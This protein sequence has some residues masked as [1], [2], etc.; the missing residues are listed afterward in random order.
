MTPPKIYSDHFYTYER[1]WRGHEVCDE[2]VPVEPTFN[3]F[4]RFDYAANIKS[5]DSLIPT[6]LET[7]SSFIKKKYSQLIKPSSVVDS[8]GHT[9]TTQPRTKSL[10]FFR[11]Y[12]PHDVA[13]KHQEFAS[14]LEMLSIQTG[15]VSFEIIATGQKILLVFSCA[16]THVDTFISLTSS[17][18]PSLIV[19]R[20]YDD[21]LAAFA[22]TDNIDIIEFAPRYEFIRP[23]RFIEQ[24]QTDPFVPIFSSL[25]N[26]QRDEQ[27]ALQILFHISDKPW[28][29]TIM[30]ALHNSLGQQFF[31]QDPQMIS[32][33]EQKYLHKQF[34][35]IIRT[36]LCAHASNRKHALKESITNALIE[37]TAST[38]NQL[39]AF[40][41]NAR[42]STTC[43][44]DLVNRATHRKPFVCNSHELLLLYMLQV[45]Q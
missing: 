29:E 42:D 23:L 7:F 11:I 21:P 32:C 15:T 5:D 17:F 16:V 18:L 38:S 27:V 4:K 26:L 45:Q 20:I 25:E 31:Y 30:H 1:Q 12:V 9:I 13:I 39:Q 37:S 6:Y 33:A 10:A 44:I 8:A 41:C 22:K 43:I 24:C 36:A 40:N 14:F 19:Q 34:G 28:K 2:Q 3:F 35:I